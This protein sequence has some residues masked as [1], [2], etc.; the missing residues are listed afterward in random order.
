RDRA[1]DRP[2]EQ[3]GTAVGEC[4][5]QLGDERGDPW[6][7]IA[8]RRARRGERLL[9]RTLLRL[10]AR[11]LGLDG[12]PVWRRRI[13][14]QE[15]VPARDPLVV[16]LAERVGPCFAGERGVIDRVAWRAARRATRRARGR[17]QRLRFALARG[18][19]LLPWID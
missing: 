17:G 16:R 18:D 11:D 14:L 19:A 4:D 2:D 12:A 10:Q 5:R 8:R 6:R 9:A 1:F 15:L 3:R 7:A 13:G